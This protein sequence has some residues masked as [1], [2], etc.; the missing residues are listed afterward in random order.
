MNKFY[1][2]ILYIKNNYLKSFVIFCQSFKYIKIKNY[3]VIKYLNI[4]KL[5]YI[6]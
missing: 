1:P 4:I 2:I 6:Y 3:I 5:K